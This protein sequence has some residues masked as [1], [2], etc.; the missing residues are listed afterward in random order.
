VR[1]PQSGFTLIELLVVIA[2]MSVLMSLLMPALMKSKERANQI[3]C[4]SNLKQIAISAMQYSDDKRFFPHKGRVSELDG[5][6][7]SDVAARCIRSLTFF[8][9]NDNPETYNCPSSMD[10]MPVMTNAAKT[11]PRRFGWSGKASGRPPLAGGEGG[12]LALTNMSNLSYGWTKR[13]LQKNSHSA[14]ILAG[15]KARR[16]ESEAHKDHMVGN[17]GDCIVVVSIDA[18]TTRVTP[19]GDTLN[20][21]SKL[22]AVDG[23]G[24]GVLDDEGGEDGAGASSGSSSGDSKLAALKAPGNAKS[25]GG[26]MPKTQPATR[27]LMLVTPTGGSTKPQANSSKSG[28]TAKSKFTI[29]SR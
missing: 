22:T 14:S 15:D 8:N 21:G 27:N 24:L 12:D 16:A 7:E 11:D 5:S 9:Y 6:Y 25:S 17:H 28:G 26:T 23:A 18:H 3:K 29:P 20:T 13:G 10:N 4:T 2:I 1:R 19:K